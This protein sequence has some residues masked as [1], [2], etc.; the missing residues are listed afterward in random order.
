METNI[1]LNEQQSD[2]LKEML[3]GMAENENDFYSKKYQ[4]IAEQILEKINEN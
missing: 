1:T 2:F 4:M 3:E